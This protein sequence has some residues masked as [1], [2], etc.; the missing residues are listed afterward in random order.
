[1]K[2][3]LEKI[4]QEVSVCQKC[5]LARSRTK[6]VPGSGAP[7]AQIMFVGEGPGKNED[8]QGEPFVGAAGRILSELLAGIGLGREDVFITNVVKCRPPLN[9]DPLPEEVAA[10]HDYLERQVALIR[11]RIIVLLGRHAMDRFLPGL[12]I[13]RD[14]GQPKRLDGQVYYPIY[15]PAATIYHQALRQDLEKD[16]Q[17]LPKIIALLEREEKAAAGEA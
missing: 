6:T 14:H 5:A 9:R 1:M 13:S 3:T 4:K 11:P 7:R 12:K 8:E 10:C 16:F 15:H 17:K 2:D